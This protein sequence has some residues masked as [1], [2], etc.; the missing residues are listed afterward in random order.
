LIGYFNP[1]LQQFWN[2]L[3]IFK[4]DFD[5]LGSE[6][7][8]IILSV[9]HKGCFDLTISNIN[10]L[11]LPDGFWGKNPS[12]VLVFHLNRRNLWNLRAVIDNNNLDKA[13]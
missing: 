11:D 2:S 6:K 1:G 10:G 8:P 13:R 5:K 7:E 3:K 12:Y 4:T 9:E